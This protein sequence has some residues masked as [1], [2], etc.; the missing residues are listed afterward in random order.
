VEVRS[1]WTSTELCGYL[2]FPSAAQVFTI[3]RE[4][5]EMVSQK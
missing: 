2:D 4:V 5:A 1:L 3:R